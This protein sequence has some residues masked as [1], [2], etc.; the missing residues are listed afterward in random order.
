MIT[1]LLF[2]VFFVLGAVSII[3]ERHNKRK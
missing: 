3:W 1:A 2:M